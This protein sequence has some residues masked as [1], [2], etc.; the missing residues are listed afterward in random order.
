MVINLGN[1]QYVTAN[2]P[3]YGEAEKILNNFLE[4]IQLEEN[5][6]NADKELADTQ[7]K[8]N[9]ALKAGEKLARNIEKNKKEKENLER[10]L[11]D[12]KTELEKL[13]TDIE[14]NKKD[15]MKAAEETE[16][17]KKA[18]ESA[19]TRVATGGKQ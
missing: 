4:K 19:K 9:D 5:V 3:K 16:L 15:Q 8:Q 12:N 6:R 10:K 1:E 7:D 14:T 2:S 11:V 13:L 18:V 17:K